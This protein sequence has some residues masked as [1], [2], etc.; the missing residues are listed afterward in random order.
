MEGAN[1]CGIFRTFVLICGIIPSVTRDEA[2][3]NVNAMIKEIKLHV[4]PYFLGLP[5]DF[6][7]T[8][9]RLVRKHPS[10]IWLALPDGINVLSNGT[11]IEQL[12][13]R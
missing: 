7:P 10:R 11:P 1:A 6:V 9:I 4:R 12:N 13:N 5:D 8:S 2:D 3:A